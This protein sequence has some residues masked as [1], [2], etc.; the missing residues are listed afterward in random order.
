MLKPLLASLA[1]FGLAAPALAQT[2]TSVRAEYLVTLGGINVATVGIGLEDDGSRYRLDVAARVTGLGNLVT[3]GTAEAS[4]AGRATAPALTSEEFDLTTRAG[5]ES[6]SVDISY[7]GRNVTAFRVT[8][9]LPDTYDRIAIER[10]HLNG[11]GDMVSAFI[12]KN[13][14]LDQSLC[15][16]TLRI[17]TGVERFDIAMSFA[18]TDT[19]TSPRTAYQGPVILCSLDYRPI[20]GH[21]QSSEITQYL[22][23]VSRILIWYAPLGETGY[24]IPYRALVGTGAGDLS[25]ILVGLR[26]P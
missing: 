3:S 16:R 15:Q 10:S 26:G 1:L 17:F 5:G 7:S 21:Y 22:D 6:F 19:A 14:V 23:Q 4:V 18:G 11:V 2:Q 9:P 8:P 20:S 24:F 13:G 25:M 12:V